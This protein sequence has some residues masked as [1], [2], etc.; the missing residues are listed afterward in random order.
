MWFA[1]S[2]S[3]ILTRIAA[4]AFREGCIT[5]LRGGGLEIYVSI[6]QLGLG[7]RVCEIL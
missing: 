6:D 2:R 4:R 3:L 1:F 7:V 5:I